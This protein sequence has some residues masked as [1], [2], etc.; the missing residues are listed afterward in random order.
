MSDK[1]PRTG[2]LIGYVGAQTAANM[3]GVSRNRVA[4]MRREGRLRSLETPIGHLYPE[5]MIRELALSREPV[6]A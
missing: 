3:L 6:D 1:E 5:S 4:Q 2:K